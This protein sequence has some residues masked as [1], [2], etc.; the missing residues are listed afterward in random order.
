MD[1]DK[2]L[3]VVIYKISLGNMYIYRKMIKN[4]IFEYND[5]KK[6]MVNIWI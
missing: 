2:S 1:F 6:I 5:I 4:N 3:N